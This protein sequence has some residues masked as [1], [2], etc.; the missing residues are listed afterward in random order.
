MP[1]VNI[2]RTNWTTYKQCEVR[3][4]SPRGYFYDVVWIDAELARKNA[5]LRDS[6][7]RQ[8]YVAEVYGTKKLQGTREAFTK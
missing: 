3:R 4:P 7:G 5:Q 1:E 6:R 2:D 8:W